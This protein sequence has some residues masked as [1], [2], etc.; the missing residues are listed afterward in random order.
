MIDS[1]LQVVDKL[2]GR[3][4]W[5]TTP[6]EGTPVMQQTKASHASNIHISSDSR[7]SDNGWSVGGELGEVSL[8]WGSGEIGELWIS[9]GSLVVLSDVL[10]NDV[11]SVNNLGLHDMN[12]LGST[13]MSTGHL[14]EHL[15]DGTAEGG[16]S[17][18]L[19]H[20]DD[21]CSGLVLEGNTVV[22]D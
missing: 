14:V 6:G 7:S 11:L 10:S 15:G 13:G 20:V 4:A 1:N 21:T 16:V 18:L 8:G 22:L 12:G 9:E 3:P 19:V 2:S 5:L 17:E